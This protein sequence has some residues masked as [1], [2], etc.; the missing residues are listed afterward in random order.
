[1]I[2]THNCGELG[3][4]DTGKDVA[5]CG[6]IDSRRDHGEII[7]MDLRDKHGRTQ[8]VFDPEKNKEAHVKAHQLRNEYCVKVK[9]KVSPRPEGT[10]NP[11]IATGRIEIDVDRIEVLSESDTPP[12]EIKDDVDVS[13][14]MRLKYRYLDLRRVPMQKRLNIKHKLY[15]HITDFLDNEGFVSV[16]TPMLTKSTPEGA[17]D[18]LVPSRVHGGSFYALPQSPQ[19][20]KQILMVAGVEKYFQI[21]RCFRDEDLRADRQPEFTQLDM[22]MSFVEEEDI[23]GVCERLFKAIFSKVMDMEIEIPFERVSYRHVMEKYGSDKPD[24]R[25]GV[26]LQDLTE[27]AGRSSFKVFSNAVSSGG[28]VMALAAPGYADISRKDIDDLTAFVGEY[29]A[30]G[31]AYFKVTEEGLSSPIT[32][33]FKPGELELFR[34]KTGAS[35]GDMI[36]M[37]ADAE[38]VVWDSLGALR[39]KIGREKNLIEKDKFDF[40]WVVDFPLFKFNKDEKRWVSEHHP[41]TFFR[42]EDLEL[43]EKGEFGK[44]RSL[45]Y[46]LVLNGSE[47]GSGSIRIHKRDVQ[48]RIFDILGLTEEEAESKF[49][50]LLEAFNYGPPPHGGIAFGMDR[51]VTLFTGDSSIREVIPFPKTQKGICPLSGAPSYVD[52]RQL[53]ELGIKHTKRTKKEG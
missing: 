24:R 25:F 6:W 49:G 10:V 16:E 4:E 13:E 21:V 18:Y 30:K 37:V 34:E 48:K 45:S 51:L 31:L 3:S 43:L 7:F 44:I 53:R 46:D 2:R 12:F 1:M 32:K 11:K 15:R 28:R 42:Q 14:E 33:F 36:F 23:F 19:I 8:I 22:E 38:E 47:I 40:L 20:F 39:L 29:G 27:E 5:L 17:R 52:D 50:F 26:H 41:F 35:A 9:G